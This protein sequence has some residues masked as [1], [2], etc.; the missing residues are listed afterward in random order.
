MRQLIDRVLAVLCIGAGA[1]SG[2]AGAQGDGDGL[3]GSWQG[4][5]RCAKVRVQAH[6]KI[7]L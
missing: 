6:L 2:V 4:A 7:S 3:P 5:L 1:L